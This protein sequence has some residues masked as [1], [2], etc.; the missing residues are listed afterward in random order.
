MSSFRQQ[1]S[2][3][4][5]ILGWNRDA[6]ARAT[7]LKAADGNV[8]FATIE[9]KSMST[10]TSIKRV[11][12]VAAAA[13]TLGGFSAVSA[14][15]ANNVSLV[16][17]KGDGAAVAPYST[18][19]GVAGPANSVQVQ[20]IQLAGKDELATI[21]G[22]TFASSDTTTAVIATG[23]ASVSRAA[24][25]A[26]AA[27]LTIP[28][29]TVG[30]ITVN[31]YTGSNGIYSSTI[32]ESVVITVNATA[33]SGV[34]SA[35][36]STI[37]LASGETYTAA[38]TDATVVASST[39]NWDTAVATVQVHLLDALGARY[40]DTVTATITSGPGVLFGSNDS[41]T[42]DVAAG[43]NNTFSATSSA[44]LY[45]TTVAGVSSN[46]GELRD[47][48][49]GIYA[50][51][52]A[53]TSTITLKNAAG[54]VLGTKTVTFYS[55]TPAKVIPTVL[56]GYV[57]NS[58]TAT[59]KVFSVVV[60]D[61]AGNQISNPTI[62]MT[63]ASGSTVGQAGSCTWNSTDLVSYCTAL[64]TSA[65]ALATTVDNTETY[66]FTSGTATATASV[67]FVSGNL[68]AITIVAPASADPGTKV[69]YTLTATGANGSP[70]PDGA[71]VPGALLTNADPS[72]NASATAVPF[73]KG[74]TITLAA[75]VATD[76]TYAPFGGTLTSSWTVAGTAATAQTAAYDGSAFTAAGIV[77]TL[78]A[79]TVVGSDVAVN[80]SADAS[81]ATDAANAATDAA[82]AAADAADNATQAASEA[83]AAVNSLATTVASLIAGIKA[84]ITSL[85]NLITKIK[86]KVGA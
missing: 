49:F 78:T 22:S 74:E 5:R 60:Q 25:Y 36:K 75:G 51:G 84:Q 38:T 6:S 11:A 76:Y 27:T 80:G 53:G 24:G 47:I 28:T 21:S 30:T 48:Y 72:L 46:G 35:A 70:L 54:T 3:S 79:T 20:L 44:P 83:L 62:T 15:A 39:A 16:F 29:P 14:H 4:I 9:R 31:L 64:A 12:L 23:G 43:Q 7:H 81:A 2:S 34:F 40:K 63:V 65:N 82:N 58:T 45:S 41:T 61:S 59:N 52:Q 37:Y 32:A 68:N 69:T 8:P 56:K 77:K 50:N 42:I 17:Y 26:G 33:S 10:K 66:T 85:T 18:G 73:G 1:V 13:L 55:T 86:N 71:Y 67:K 57:L 19:N